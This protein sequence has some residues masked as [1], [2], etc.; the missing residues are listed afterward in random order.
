MNLNFL[1]SFSFGNTYIE[2]SYY[3]L[4]LNLYL[5]FSSNMHAYKIMKVL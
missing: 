4:N 3:L 5:V 1:Y 2:M